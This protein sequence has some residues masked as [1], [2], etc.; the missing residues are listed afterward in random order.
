[1]CCGSAC[2]REIAFK[3]LFPDV[4]GLSF[5]KHGSHVV[6]KVIWNKDT[7]RPATSAQLDALWV[8][9]FADTGNKDEPGPLLDRLIPHE[10]GNYVVSSCLEVSLTLP[11]WLATPRS[12]APSLTGSTCDCA[13][14]TVTPATCKSL[15]E[16]LVQDPR[17]AASEHGVAHASK[18]LCIQDI[19][20]PRFLLTCGCWCAGNEREPAAHHQAAHRSGA[21][22]YGG[23]P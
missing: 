3:D 17:P 21:A 8:R 12:L 5:D 14:F 4:G 10:Y 6:E 18:F 16:Q 2:C 15:L 20:H 7:K 13:A 11:K 23:Q 19:M 9:L 22:R 1:M